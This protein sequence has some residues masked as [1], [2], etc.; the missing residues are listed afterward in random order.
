MLLV[1]LQFVASCKLSTAIIVFNALHQTNKL[2]L[3]MNEQETDYLGISIGSLGSKSLSTHTHTHDKC[4]TLLAYA[5][6]FTQPDLT[7]FASPLIQEAKAPKLIE[8]LDH[9]PIYDFVY[10][11]E[12][13][14]SSLE[15]R[16]KVNVD[17]HNSIRRRLITST[18]LGQTQFY[19]NYY[20][21]MMILIAIVIITE[22]IIAAH[23]YRNSPTGLE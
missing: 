2:R 8:N 22:I 13:V 6:T 14:C 9:V 23:D 12:S 18:L 11:L 16:S 15:T 20:C 5:L 7:A 19:N 4:I 10:C 17:K 3:G 1:L 21:A